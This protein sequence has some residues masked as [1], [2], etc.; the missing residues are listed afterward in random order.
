VTPRA[1]GRLCVAVQLPSRH[2]TLA[3]DDQRNCRTAPTSPCP[4]S[5]GSTAAMGDT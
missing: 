2:C 3:A 1:A 5:P 4:T